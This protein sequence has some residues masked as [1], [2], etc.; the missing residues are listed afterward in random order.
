M[1][2]ACRAQP[3]PPHPSPRPSA[4]SADL[5]ATKATACR[6]EIGYSL[7]CN[8]VTLFED[9]G[10][11]LHDGNVIHPHRPTSAFPAGVSA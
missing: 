3:E 5:E 9:T 7:L 2:R 10:V 6:P 1:G 11:L 8:G 4:H